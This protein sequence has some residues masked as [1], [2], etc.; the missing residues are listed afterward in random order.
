MVIMAQPGRSQ[1]REAPDASSGTGAEVPNHADIKHQK[2]C[3]AYLALA[4]LLTKEVPPEHRGS[5]SYMFEA[6]KYRDYW[7]SWFLL[8]L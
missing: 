5:G 1:R 2:G 4:H 7:E 6:L 8:A 3:T